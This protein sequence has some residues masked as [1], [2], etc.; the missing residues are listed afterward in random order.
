MRKL[1][2]D[3]IFLTQSQDLNE[4]KDVPLE[5]ISILIRGFVAFELRDRPICMSLF[6]LVLFKRYSEVAGCKL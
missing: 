1:F 5:F 4:S 3:K 2:Y 6:K